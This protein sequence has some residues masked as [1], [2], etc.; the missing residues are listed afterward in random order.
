MADV[1]RR[2]NS[3]PKTE[4]VYLPVIRFPITANQELRIAATDCKEFAI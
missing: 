1:A 4:T 3:A 2:R